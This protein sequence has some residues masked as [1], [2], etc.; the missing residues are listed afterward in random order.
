MGGYI[1]GPF[2]D[3]TPRLH[4]KLPG[5]AY[6]W[7]LLGIIIEPIQ[8]QTLDKPVPTRPGGDVRLPFV[9]AVTLLSS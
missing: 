9:E 6:T 7:Y 8:V 2:L 3:G 4:C 1:C 5:K